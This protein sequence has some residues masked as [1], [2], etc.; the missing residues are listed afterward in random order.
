MERSRENFQKNIGNL[1]REDD[2]VW[3]K[4]EK[5]ANSYTF[6]VKSTE[7]GQWQPVASGVEAEEVPS[8]I[9]FMWKSW[10]EEAEAS[11]ALSDVKVTPR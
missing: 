8:R 3:L 7:T 11:Y 9:G 1:P 2:K 5:W 6:H 4:I 10:E